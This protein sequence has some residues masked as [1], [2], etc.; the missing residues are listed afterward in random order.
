LEAIAMQTMDCK[1]SKTFSNKKTVSTV[2][3]LNIVTE[4]SIF[5]QA[6]GGL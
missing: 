5:G 4:G 3:D 2:L 1:Y 6:F